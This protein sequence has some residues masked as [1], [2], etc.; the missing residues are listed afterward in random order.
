MRVD[1]NMLNIDTASVPEQKDQ[2]YLSTDCHRTD[3]RPT[4]FTFITPGFHLCL[5]RRFPPRVAVSCLA[6]GGKL[7]VEFTHSLMLVGRGTTT[8]RS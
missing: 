1:Y 4:H 5:G 3:P 8:D 2:N 7:K 6:Q